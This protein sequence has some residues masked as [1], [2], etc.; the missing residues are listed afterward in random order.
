MANI[1]QQSQRFQYAQPIFMQ[2]D[3]SLARALRDLMREQ[4]SY[5]L[6]SIHLDEAAPADALTLAE[7]AR[8]EQFPALAQRYSDYLY[9]QHP[10]AVQEAKPVQSLWAQWYFGLLLPPLM[11]ALLA[12]SRALD[13]SPQHIHVQFH[14]HGHPCAFWIATHEDEEARYLT[15]PQRIDRLIQQHLIPA[16]NAIAQHGGINARL[17]W[18]NMGFSFHW[19]LGELKTLLDE[20]IILQLEQTIFFTSRLQDGSDNPL[21]RTMLPRGGE[22]VRRSCCQR[23]RIPD[24]ERCGNCTLSV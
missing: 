23:Y 13:C 6:E 19:F 17:I 3:R 7:W 5:M 21:Y 11:L 10:D 22:M 9:R 4:H 15:A 12:E 14:E 20:A 2:G 24:V 16:V 1:R 18:N 8:P